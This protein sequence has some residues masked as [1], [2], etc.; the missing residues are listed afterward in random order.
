MGASESASGTSTVRSSILL[1]DEWMKNR[2]TA[3][4]EKG[5]SLGL[6]YIVER[7]LLL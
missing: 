7:A 5:V 1:T 3:S 4:N 6:L 2:R